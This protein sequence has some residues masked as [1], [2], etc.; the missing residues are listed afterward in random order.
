MATDEISAELR[1]D[2]A[3]LKADLNALMETVRE[4]SAEQGRAVYGR[5]RETG[6]KARAQVQA[7]QDSVERYVEA[8][9]LSSI[10]VA[11]G[12]GFVVGTLLGSR[13]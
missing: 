12:V 6:D 1:Q 10:L 2:L 13:R 8:R 9:P 7:A 11:F 5:L 4:L 3:T